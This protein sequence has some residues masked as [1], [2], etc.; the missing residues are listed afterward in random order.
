MLMRCTTI[1]LGFLLFILDI[2]AQTVRNVEAS[3]ITG[4]DFITIKYTL[5]DTLPNRLFRTSILART[6]EGLFELSAL[7]GTLGDSI[8]LGTHEVI[9]DAYKDWQR[10][11]GDIRIQVQAIPMF[12]FEAP[13]K[14][15]S[16]KRDE[17]ITFAWYGDN[18]T[19][20]EL[21]IELYQ[22]NKRLDT[23]DVISRLDQ[24]TWKVPTT[25]KPGGGY[26]IRLVGTPLSSIDAYSRE[27]VIARKIPLSYIY[28]GAGVL[29]AGVV[30]GITRI[31]ERIGE[32]PKTTDIGPR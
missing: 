18:S 6:E 32:P 12:R 13:I 20:D 17:P 24:Y 9:W 26:R 16:V 5:F 1:I 15:V 22:Y 25:L 7:S 8:P 2:Q 3:P 28:V 21:R 27:F 10:F 19:L 29:A 31:I 23:L 4:T 14:K 30:Y 11:S